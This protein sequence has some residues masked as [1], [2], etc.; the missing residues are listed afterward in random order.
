M[1][2]RINKKVTSTNT[3]TNIGIEQ[4]SFHYKAEVEDILPER[5]A[6]SPSGASIPSHL[7]SLYELSPANS[8]LESLSSPS[9]TDNK[10]L[11]P[12]EYLSLFNQTACDIEALGKKTETKDLLDAVKSM[13][14][15]KVDQNYLA[16][17]FYLL[18]QV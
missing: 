2:S 3:A 13:K 17:A 10:V 8:V 9:I 14:K 6:I 15:I 16:T 11:R 4:L 5:Y 12:R 18:L 1:K 7:D